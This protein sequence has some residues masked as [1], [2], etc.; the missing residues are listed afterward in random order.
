M[1]SEKRKERNKLNLG[2]EL[3]DARV[4]SG[5]TQKGLASA[6]GLEYYTMISQMELG[7]ISIPAALW[8]DIALHLNMDTSRWILSCLNEYQPDVYKAL[9]QNRSLKECGDVL[10]MQHK[11][12]LDDMLT[13][14]KIHSELH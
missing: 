3:K 12:Q 14:V 7:Y 4:R 10:N 6:L 2:S 13:H 8:H 1:L 5:F 11:G 9:F